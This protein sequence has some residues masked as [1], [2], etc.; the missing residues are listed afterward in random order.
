MCINLQKKLDS[1]RF[2]EFIL[3]IMVS[4]PD[5]VHIFAPDTGVSADVSGQSANIKLKTYREIFNYRL[6]MK[7]KVERL[8]AIREIIS[9][10]RVGSQEE[11][12]RSLVARGFDLTQATLSRDLKQ[13]QIAKIAMNDGGYMYILSDTGMGKMMSVKMASVQGGGSTACLSLRFSGNLA[14]IRTRP[15][16]AGSVA[17]DI[18]SADLDEII[19]SIAGDDTVVLVLR[20]DVSRKDIKEALAAYIPSVI[21]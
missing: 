10:T 9:T 1:C 2:N 16:Y 4:S 21:E 3:Y 13:L 20:E 12:L 19:G 14:V 5:F 11:L 8:Q 6:R 15:G 7:K 18:D 17:Y